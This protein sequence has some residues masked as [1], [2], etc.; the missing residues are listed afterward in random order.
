MEPK[1][2]E[3]KIININIEPKFKPNKRQKKLSLPNK[4]NEISSKDSIEKRKM[5]L[6]LLL[7]NIK[8]KI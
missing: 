8:L 1:E 2:T 5:K 7:K 6:L 4:K 3:E